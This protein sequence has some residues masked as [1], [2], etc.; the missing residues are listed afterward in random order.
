MAGN[1]ADI[2]WS[3][4]KRY[5]QSWEQADLVSLVHDLFKLSPEN[6]AFLATRLLGAAAAK[7]LLESYRKRIEQA[8]YKRSGMPQEK[9]GLAGATHR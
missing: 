8:F 4:I 6:R 3:D 1:K 9:L 5:F 2:K 7:P